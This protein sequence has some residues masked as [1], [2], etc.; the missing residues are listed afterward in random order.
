MDIL[1]RFKEI[2]EPSNSPFVL[3]FGACD[4]HHSRIMLDMLQESGKKYTYHLFE[5]NSDLLQSIV[6]RLQYYLTS[7]NLLY[8]LVK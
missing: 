7:N 1:E 5:P 2:I 3:E 4:G 6:D 8:Y